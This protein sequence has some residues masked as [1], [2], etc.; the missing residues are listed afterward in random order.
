M[1]NKQN[2]WFFTLFSLILVLGIYYVTMPDEL[3]EKASIEST[4]EEKV[5]IKEVKEEN[6]LMAMRVNLEDQREEEISILTKQL[7]SEKITSTEKNNIYEQLKYLNEIQGKE[8][9]L[10][11]KIKKEFDLDCF[12]KIDTPDITT[13]C[14]SKE[15]DASL[16]NK[17]MKSIQ[18]DYENKMNI[19][20]KFQKK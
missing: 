11:K 7:A 5:Q 12:I 8:E 3:L 18:N 13:V 2:L 14:V 19:T 10:E 1:I 17:I 9:I 6:A 20:V 15:H 4:K 16:A